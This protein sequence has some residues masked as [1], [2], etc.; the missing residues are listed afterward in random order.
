MRSADGTPVV[1]VGSTFEPR[2]PSTLAAHAPQ[3]EAATGAFTAL[4]TF[5]NTV[6]STTYSDG[7]ARHL[8]R[9][10][11][12]SRCFIASA[13]SRLSL[14][15][16]APHHPTI[17]ARATDMLQGESCGIGLAPVRLAASDA[18]VLAKLLGKM[19]SG[20]PDATAKEIYEALTAIKNTNVHESIVEKLEAL[21][22]RRPN[23]SA[24]A[25][26]T[27]EATLDSSI[28]VLVP[29]VPILRKED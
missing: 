10:H 13:G 7:A 27:L 28:A 8:A 5:S 19:L 6:T 3:E 25:A 29:L 22:R 26:S 15:S 2:S 1:V 24:G 18:E 23:A 11:P 16:L 9:Y 14:V 4:D 12:H 17:V 20:P 21:H